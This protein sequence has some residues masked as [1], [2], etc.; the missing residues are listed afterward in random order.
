LVNQL[1]NR[2][3]E[4]HSDRS[5]RQAHLGSQHSV[6]Q[7]SRKPHLVNHHNPLQ[8]L[9][10]PHRL[11]QHLGSRRNQ[12]QASDNRHSDLLGLEQVAKRVPLLQLLLLVLLPVDL[13]Q[14]LHSDSPHNRRR[15]LDNPRNPHQP[16]V[17]RLSRLQHLVSLAN[18]HHPS[19]H[20]VKL[21]LPLDGR[22]SLLRL[23][24][25][26]INLHSGKQ[27]KRHL[28]LVNLHSQHL[29]LASQAN[30]RRR[31]VNQVN[32]LQ[33]SA[34]QPN[35]HQQEHLASQLL[36]QVL[37][38]HLANHQP[39]PI[40]SAPN[41]LMLNPM[42]KTWTQQHDQYLEETQSELQHNNSHRRSK[43]PH[44]HPPPQAPQHQQQN[45]S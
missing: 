27:V 33:H 40:R 23:H 30:P 11:L 3:V 32:H 15:R 2:L 37:H 7:R 38:Q 19:G 18:L 41:Q 14:A 20:R 24:R 4:V 5:P 16:L 43:Q 1:V 25:L 9:A 6:L 42:T 17:S 21:L 28:H 35:R 26:L 10:N 22:C 39:L 31:L 12:L 34:N 8:P 44:Q 29:P 13:A 36:E 45:Q